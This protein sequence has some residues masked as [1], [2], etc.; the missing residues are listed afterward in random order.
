MPKLSEILFGKK[1]KMQQPSLLT[2]PQQQ[3]FDQFLRMLSGQETGGMM[4]DVGNYYRDLMSPDSQAYSSFAAPYQRQFREDVIPGLAEQF[5]GLGSG[6]LDSS[7]FRNAAVQAG[8]DLTERL[9]SL[10]EGLRQQGVSGMSGMFQTGMTPVKEN[11]LRPATPGL[12]GSAAQ[13]IGSGLGMVGGMWGG[14][15]LSPM[16]K[17]K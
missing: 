5:A 13:G 8:T 16:F 10:R 17:G 12:L 9:A 4:G 3:L 6:G 14:N 11:V 1:E 15:L 2:G 7:S